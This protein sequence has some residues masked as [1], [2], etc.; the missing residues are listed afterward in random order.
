MAVKTLMLMFVFA[1]FAPSS[2]LAGGETLSLEKSIEEGLKNNI[3]LKVSSEQI[4]QAEYEKQETYSFFFPRIS[5]SFTYTRMD[6]A[7]EMS[8][9]GLGDLIGIPVPPVSFKVA[10]ANLYNAGVSLVQPL[11]AGG[12]IQSF[13]RKSRENIKKTSIEKDILAH[14]LAL[15]IKTSYFSILKAE[16]MLQT[17]LFLKKTAEEHLEVARAF[18]NEGLVTKTDILKTEVFMANAEQ[19]VLQAQ[20]MKAL[21]K[22]GF[23]FLLNRPLD[24]DLDIEDILGAKRDKKNLSYWTQMAYRQRPEIKKIESV[25]RMYGHDIDIEKS[26]LKPQVSLFANYQV[27]RGT[28]SSL[29][30]WQDSWNIGVAVE[31]DVWNK[32]ET[33]YRIKKAES[34][35]KEI[36]HQLLLQKQAIELEVKNSYINILFAEQEIETAKKTREKARENLRMANMLY[37][38][39]MTTNTDVLDA[40]ADLAS[41]DSSYYQALYDYHIA[42]G[43]LEQAGG[44]LPGT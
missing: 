20:N 26:G 44:I 27:D 22:A 39:G 3:A 19:K 2:F 28:Q 23:S 11:Y 21:A 35:K 5:S 29:D 37:R 17:V 42:F 7:Q 1:L 33:R 18:F 12:Q 40:Q 6:K 10:D 36:G 9:E 24:E 8:F 14:E 31:I 16:K 38:E 13:Y 30:K 4:R 43:E 41:A 25:A 34:R 32:G 15:E